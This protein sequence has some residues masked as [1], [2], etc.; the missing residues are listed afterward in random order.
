[1]LLGLVRLLRRWRGRWSRLMCMSM[2]GGA[3]CDVRKCGLSNKILILTPHL[4]VSYVCSAACCYLPYQ[5]P[6][7]RKLCRRP[8]TLLPLPSTRHVYSCHADSNSCC[9]SSSPWYCAYYAHGSFLY[10]SNITKSARQCSFDGASCDQMTLTL[11]RSCYGPEAWV[12]GM[13]LPDSPGS[14]LAVLSSCLPM[15]F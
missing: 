8:H 6:C 15:L 2:F 9:S 11:L 7:S 5:K 4:C 14:P 12:V 1:M 10:R 13:K 3:G